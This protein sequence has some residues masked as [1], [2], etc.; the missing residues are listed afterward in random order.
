[1]KKV[2]T[3][4]HRG[5][6]PIDRAEHFGIDQ[7]ADEVYQLYEK[8][9]ALLAQKRLGDLDYSYLYRTVR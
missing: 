4:Y 6:L 9:K 2:W 7:M 5:Y 3:E 8:G 1:M